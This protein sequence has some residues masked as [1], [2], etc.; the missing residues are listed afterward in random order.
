MKR[1]S[2]NYIAIY[3]KYRDKQDEKISSLAKE[4]RALH[5]MVEFLAKKVFE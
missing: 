2:D 1:Q 4:V 5:R 3:N